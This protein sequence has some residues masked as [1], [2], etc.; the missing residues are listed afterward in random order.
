[1]IDL[2]ALLRVPY[3][4][5]DELIDYDISPDG[6]RLAF[7][8]N[9]TGCWEIYEL[10]FDG[11][12]PCRQVSSGRGS[13]FSPKYNPD[14]N[15]IAHVV[16]FDGSEDYRL[17]L[18][19]P[20]GGTVD[21]TPPGADTLQPCYSWS[22]D[23]SQ[24]AYISNRSG[25]FDTYLL[26]LKTRTERLVLANGLMT[27]KVNWSPDGHW[28]AATAFTQDQD[29][30]IFIVPAEG[31]QAFQVSASD[32]RL[33]AAYPC[34]SPDSAHLFFSAERGEYHDIG[35]I[36]LASKEITW[37]TDGEGDKYK[38]ALSQDGQ[39]L[40][41]TQIL[42][43]QSWLG[44]KDLGA[45]AQVFKLASGRHESAKFTPDGRTIVF[46]FDNPAQPPDLWILSLHDL[47]C[48]QLTHSL[49]DDFPEGEFVI[50]EEI[51]YSG[52][53][54]HQVPALLYRPKQAQKPG[55]AVI[56]IHGGPN[57]LYQ[58]IWNPLMTH[59]ASRGWVVLAPNYRGS[60]GYG[61][62]WQRANRFEMGR[63]DSRDVAAGALFLAGQGLADPGRIAVTGRS[64]GGY[65]TM[66][67][68]TQF[69]DLW[70]AGSAVV[71]FLN[72][73][74][75]HAASRSDLQRWDIE[76][77]GDPQENHDLWRER[78][79]FFALDSILAP[80]QLICG[81]N[82]PRCPAEESRAARD[83]LVELG[84]EVDFIIYPDEGHGYLNVE[85]LIDSET[86]RVAFLARVLD[87]D[88]GG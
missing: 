44:F 47:T 84:R 29:F 81:A 64:H 61:K 35:S 27:Y 24:I 33:N 76:N 30:G 52:L 53:D 4:Y 80:V 58:F 62:A 32:W 43:A 13:K 66:T 17:Q 55:P 19:T 28:L 21:L 70:A 36:A 54:G 78:S 83:R 45:P 49:P 50:P 31:G 23:G 5:V 69:P 34:W 39:H 57:W 73:F 87:N 46:C 65:L 68:L 88:R 11:S 48:R 8:W 22:P 77:M 67:C 74:T 72:W 82:D 20:E 63:V 85:N 40:V 86:R 3:V 26:D 1:M 60:T 79:P 16:D 37:H 9:R 2:T 12:Q 38:P 6:R 10:W 7:A 51:W 14:G 71:P 15:S 18:I 42:G 56:N 75:S 41:Y 25:V 59:L